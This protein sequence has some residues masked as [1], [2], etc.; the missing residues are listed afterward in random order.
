MIAWGGASSAL[1]SRSWAKLAHYLNEASSHGITQIA[2]S[3]RQRCVW[4]L[5]VSH[6]TQSVYMCQ[7]LEA[8]IEDQPPPT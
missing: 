6:P 1:T 4:N 8:T 5:Y 2:L 3:I 7:R